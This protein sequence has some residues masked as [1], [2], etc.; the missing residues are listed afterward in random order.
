MP[1]MSISKSG[2]DSRIL[3]VAIRLCPP[4]K[5]RASSLC[6]DSSATASLSVRALV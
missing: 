4:A 2:A 3:R 1:L 5:S 6:L